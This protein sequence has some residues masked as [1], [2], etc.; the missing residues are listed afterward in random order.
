MQ[1]RI[2]EGLNKVKKNPRIVMSLEGKWLMAFSAS[3]NYMIILILV[4]LFKIGDAV[5]ALYSYIGE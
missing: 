3:P 2:A 1:F 5:S 4:S